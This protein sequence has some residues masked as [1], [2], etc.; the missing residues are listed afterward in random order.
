MTPCCLVDSEQCSGN[1]SFLLP[2]SKALHPANCNLDTPGLTLL[3]LHLHHEDQPVNLIMGNNRLLLHL[4]KHTITLRG[5]AV[6]LCDWYT[7]LSSYTGGLHLSLWHA[8]SETTHA[9]THTL[10]S[11][12]LMTLPFCCWLL[13]H[14]THSYFLKHVLTFFKGQWAA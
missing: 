11:G 3:A 9:R 8:I 4:T 2:T 5:N 13:T 12:A 7:E 14:K 1:V 6:L 10:G